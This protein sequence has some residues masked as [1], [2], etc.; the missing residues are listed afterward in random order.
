MPPPAGTDTT[1]PPDS[2]PPAGDDVFELPA[3]ALE[4]ITGDDLFSVQEEGRADRPAGAA[5]RPD[6]H[7]GRRRSRLFGWLGGLFGRS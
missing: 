4:E 3:V 7:T 2:R 1:A 6:S 5:D